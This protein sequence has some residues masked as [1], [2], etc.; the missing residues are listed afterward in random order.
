MLPVWTLVGPWLTFLSEE[1][2]GELNPGEQLTNASCSEALGQG[3]TRP[4]PGCLGQPTMVLRGRGRD[5][6]LLGVPWGQV[7][8][9]GTASGAGG[10]DVACQAVLRARVW[11]G[12]STAGKCQERA[13][14]RPTVEMR[15][16]Q[17]LLGKP[18]VSGT[19]WFP[20]APPPRG[21]GRL[22]VG[23]RTGC[24]GALRVPKPRAPE[25]DQAEV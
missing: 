13:G 15:G 6:V 4:C 24:P 17:Q 1:K 2:W 9:V 5:G 10:H 12:G 23:V 8:G 22:Q 7:E 3:E 14:W 18:V 19:L 11:Q 20:L 25:Q 21:P 16:T